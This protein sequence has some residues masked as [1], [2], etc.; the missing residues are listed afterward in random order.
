LHRDAKALARRLAGDRAARGTVALPRGGLV[1]AAI[2]AGEPALRIIDTI[3]VGSCEDRAQGEV[4]VLK[5]V[6]GDG[7]GPLMVHGL[8]VTGGTARVVRD[9]LPKARF[10]TICAR[11]AGGRASTPM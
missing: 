8:V 10:A 1:P 6:A 2:M 9:I 3:R 5:G 7:E 4:E 11:P